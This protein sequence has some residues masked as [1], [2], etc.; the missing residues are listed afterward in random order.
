MSILHRRSCTS[1]GACRTSCST[2]HL[3]PFTWRRQKISILPHFFKF[4]VTNQ[5]NNSTGMLYSLFLCLSSQ[6]HSIKQEENMW[7]MFRPSSSCLARGFRT[8]KKPQA[9]HAATLFAK[10]SLK[11]FPQPPKSPRKIHQHIYSKYLCNANCNLH[12]KSSQN[13]WF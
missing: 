5:A 2:C 7:D 4:I 3:L 1:T 6:K 8:N 9:Q 11:N 13:Q 10:F 12:S